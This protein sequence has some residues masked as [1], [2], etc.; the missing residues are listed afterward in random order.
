LSQADLP[1]SSEDGI[2]RYKQYVESAKTHTGG[3]SASEWFSKNDEVFSM[4]SK[5]LSSKLDDNSV[6]F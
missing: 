1:N 2:K 6:V 5:V 4:S 3:E